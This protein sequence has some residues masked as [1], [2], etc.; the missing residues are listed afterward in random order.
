MSKN[1]TMHNKIPDFRKVMH[2]I[3]KK[4]TIVT[5]VIGIFVALAAVATA[6][7]SIRT[8]FPATSNSVTHTVTFIAN[9]NHFHIQS[10]IPGQAQQLNGGIPTRDGYV[11][12]CWNTESDAVGIDFKNGEYHYIYKDLTLYA[13][14]KE[15]EIYSVTFIANGEL[16]Q[17]QSFIQGQAQLLNGG[18]PIRD[19][20]TFLCWNTNSSGTGWDYYNDN[21]YYIYSDITFYAVWEIQ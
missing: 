5:W 13:V 11:F 20:Y 1:K 14:W 7:A 15:A 18:I 19:G 4:H 21:N 10:F 17:T 2:D 3:K 16:F 9:G 6:V 8:I 12:L